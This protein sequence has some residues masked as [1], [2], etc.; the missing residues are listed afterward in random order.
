MLLDLAE[1]R[2]FPSSGIGDGGGDRQYQSF[3]SYLWGL[4]ADCDYEP[5]R[6]EPIRRVGGLQGSSVLEAI[7]FEV[8][9]P[10]APGGGQCRMAQGEGTV[11]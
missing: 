5:P 3:P 2:T 8:L 4:I 10:A 1:Y 11:A 9:V 6:T 7:P